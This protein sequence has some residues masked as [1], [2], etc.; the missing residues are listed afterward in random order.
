MKFF[1][2]P[3][4]WLERVYI[5]VLKSEFLVIVLGLRT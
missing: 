5:P 4:L 3:S 2:T 1:K